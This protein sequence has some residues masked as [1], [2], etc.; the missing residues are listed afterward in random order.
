MGFQTDV[1]MLFV[2]SGWRDNSFDG[3]EQRRGEE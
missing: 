1:I 2:D 3:D